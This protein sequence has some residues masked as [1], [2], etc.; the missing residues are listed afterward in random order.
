MPKTE[1]TRAIAMNFEVIP[2]KKIG[3]AKIANFDDIFRRKN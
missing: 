2:S 3:C 1:V